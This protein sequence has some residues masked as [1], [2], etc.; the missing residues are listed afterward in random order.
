MELTEAHF[1][2]LS[3][4]DEYMPGPEIDDLL[5]GVHIEAGYKDERVTV[6]ERLTPDEAQKATLE[7]FDDECL[8]VI[9]VEKHEDEVERRKLG[10]QEARAWLE[11]VLTWDRADEQSRPS[12]TE[13]ELTR[14]GREEFERACEI[15]G[16]ERD[17]RYAE[18]NRLNDEFKH[19]NPDFW[20]A[21]LQWLDDLSRWTEGGYKG[22][23]PEHP[24]WPSRSST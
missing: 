4:A 22:E 10:G 5:Y 17:R 15:Y 21:H 7:L 1:F 13:L 24:E 18:A 11:D 14:R 3:V 19:E 2:V 8:E 16:P 6:F 23:K 20:V 12:I 9:V